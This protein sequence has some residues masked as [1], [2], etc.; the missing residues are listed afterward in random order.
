MKRT[1]LLLALLACACDYGVYKPQG[2]HVG[3][4]GPLTP[5]PQPV[6]NPF[7]SDANVRVLSVPAWESSVAISPVHPNVVLATAMERV[8]NPVFACRIR[9]SED[10][11]A[12]W[13]DA[14]FLPLQ[15]TKNSYTGHG[16]PVLTF[17]RTG[18]AYCAVLLTAPDAGHPLKSGL[19]V[20]KSTDEGKTWVAQT[21]AEREA[22]NGRLPIFDDKEWLA[23]DN[24]GGPNDGTLYLA[25]IRAN[26]Y[27][28]STTSEMLLT[29]SRDGGA[30]WSEPRSFGRVG[31]AYLAVGPNGEVY[32]SHTGGPGYVMERSRDG[33][34]TF[35]ALAPPAR[36]SLPAGNLPNSR[37]STNVLQQFAVDLSPTAT[38]GNLYFVFPGDGATRGA[39]PA[40]VQLTRS[41]DG[42]KTWSAP[43]R[44][45]AP[46]ELK[47]DAL[48][49]TVAVDSMTGEVIAA[50]ID[51]RDDA[52]NV[53]A[54]LYAT[55]SRDGGR[56]WQTAK[57]FSSPFSIDANFLGHYN[58]VAIQNTTRI[59]SFSD[60]GGNFAAARLD[61]PPPASRR[62]TVRQ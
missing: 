62:R 48:L 1:C 6:E 39:F 44:L 17:D 13:S 3:T 54:R 37:T 35:E 19:A 5:V 59:A 53:R 46:P 2:M 61:W 25:W 34:A 43:V 31:A 49:P 27:S 9:R 28:D 8:G 32:F 38:R 55:R 16:D 23:V 30:T 24:S 60:A 21:L 33:G 50:W 56:T 58:G 22:V 14:G 45:S 12:T 7:A 29:R 57:P 42:G 4:N 52:N 40:S 47:R 20:M 36:L 11:G 10:G 41:E 15:L 18:T 26:G 51:R